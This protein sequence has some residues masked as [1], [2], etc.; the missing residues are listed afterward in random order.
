MNSST[1]ELDRRGIKALLSDKLPKY[2][3]SGNY[4]S[5]STIPPSTNIT[6]PPQTSTTDATLSPLSTSPP[7]PDLDLCSF[8]LRDELTLQSV[9]ILPGLSDYCAM[10]CDAALE[11]NNILPDLPPGHGYDRRWRT[12]TLRTPSAPVVSPGEL[13]ALCTQR[14]RIAA[15]ISA[16][17]LNQSTLHSSGLTIF[18]EV[19]EPWENTDYIF[20]HS[21]NNSEYPDDS[22]T[23]HLHI[24]RVAIPELQPFTNGLQ[25]AVDHALTP[26]LLYYLTEID[27]LTD[28]VTRAIEYICSTKGNFEWERR[29][30][31]MNPH[32]IPS[33]KQYH[34]ALTEIP[35]VGRLAGPDSMIPAHIIEDIKSVD[36]PWKFKRTKSSHSAV[37][38]ARA[39]VLLRK[40]W[41]KLVAINGTFAVIE[42]G[43]RQIICM[44]HRYSQTMLLSK[45][46]YIPRNP[47]NK[48]DPSP[49]KVR[50]GLNIAATLDV[51]WRGHL[52]REAAR[53]KIDLPTKLLW[54]HHYADVTVRQCTNHEGLDVKYFPGSAL[55][56]KP[57]RGLPDHSQVGGSTGALGTLSDTGVPAKRIS[58]SG[59]CRRC[60]KPVTAP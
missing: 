18:D 58:R 50:I 32:C 16:A 34:A 22:S 37:N 7:S 2:S 27:F 54:K 43:N 57:S 9:V 52:W 12:P 33:C 39:R 19:K 8:H 47:C 21:D 20:W 11:D 3:K 26:F 59:A 60:S 17:V 6:A 49:M 48:E 53:L 55:G 29:H 31:Q 5:T 51:A 25:A 30:P 23:A 41:T 14:E 38:L 36:G 13:Q 1:I 40:V 4:V 42:D 28:G 35:C 45:P 56:G 46:T 15:D 44:R 10:L 24:D